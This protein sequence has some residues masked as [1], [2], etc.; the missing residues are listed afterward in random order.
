MINLFLSQFML[1]ICSFMIQGDSGGPLVTFDGTLVGVVSRGSKDCPLE[2]P[3]VF[4]QVS[5]YVDWIRSIAGV[6]PSVGSR[7]GQPDD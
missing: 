3:A 2:I 7:F 5:H 6:A 1:I 4:T